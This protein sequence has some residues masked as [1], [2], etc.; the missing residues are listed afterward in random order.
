MWPYLLVLIPLLLAV[1]C[2]TVMHN[3]VPKELVKEIKGDVSPKRIPCC[4]VGLHLL[5]SSNGIPCSGGGA[6]FAAI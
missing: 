5:W 6:V 2:A 4:H 3:T 1:G